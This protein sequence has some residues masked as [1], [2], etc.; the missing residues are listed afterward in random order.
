MLIRRALYERLRRGWTRTDVLARTRVDPA[1]LTVIEG[2]F[3]NDPAYQHALRELARLYGVEPFLLLEKV[4]IPN[5][6]GTDVWEWGRRG[7]W[8]KVE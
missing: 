1:Y 5:D 3:H 8:E 6:L 2:E 7:Y 4:D